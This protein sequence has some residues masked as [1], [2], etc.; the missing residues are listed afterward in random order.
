MS[1]RKLTLCV[2]VIFAI[3]FAKRVLQS[4]NFAMQGNPAAE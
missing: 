2:G 1:V 4:P 3:L